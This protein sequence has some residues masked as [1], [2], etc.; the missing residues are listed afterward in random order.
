MFDRK[1]LEADL[2]PTISQAYGAPQ[3][4]NRDDVLIPPVAK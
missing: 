3:L 4:A 2:V 1:N